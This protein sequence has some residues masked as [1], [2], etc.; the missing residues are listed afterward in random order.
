M[1]IVDNYLPIAIRE[2]ILY[3]LKLFASIAIILYRQPN[4]L[5]FYVFILAIYYFIMNSFINVSR[6]IK[7]WETITRSP[8]YSHLGESLD[9]VSTIR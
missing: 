1:E 9:G 2:L 4:S 6:Q 3:L 5:I 8:I 7:R